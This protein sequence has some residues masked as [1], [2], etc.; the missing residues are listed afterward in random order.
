MYVA[1]IVTV[2]NQLAQKVLGSRVDNHPRDTR[3]KTEGI[4][5]T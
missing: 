1:S 5:G 4:R 2:G 3:R